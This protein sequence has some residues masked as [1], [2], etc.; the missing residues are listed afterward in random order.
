MVTVITA[1]GFS[2]AALWW[3][4]SGLP[5]LGLPRLV[6]GVALGLAVPLVVVALVTSPAAEAPAATT[7][8]LAAAA[9]R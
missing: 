4:R 9:G 3:M 1:V 8:W 6:A 2:L 7:S 5:R